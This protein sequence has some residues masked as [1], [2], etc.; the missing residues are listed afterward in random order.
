MV[1]RTL[2]EVFQFLNFDVAVTARF[3]PNLMPVN[4]GVILA[5]GISTGAKKFFSHYIGTYDRIKDDKIIQNICGN[6]LMRWR[7]GQLSLNAVIPSIKM[8][9]FRDGE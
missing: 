7:G 2:D 4:E 1:L 8:V 9:D 6:D 5:K 3:A